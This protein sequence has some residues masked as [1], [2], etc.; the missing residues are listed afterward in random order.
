M[1]TATTTLQSR[2]RLLQD[3]LPAQNY[4]E[5]L[6]TCNAILNCQLQ[7]AQH[8]QSEGLG[9]TAALLKAQRT[10]SV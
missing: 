6:A 5:A 4:L 3:V 1:E 8:Y 10:E 2:I 9:R 7:L